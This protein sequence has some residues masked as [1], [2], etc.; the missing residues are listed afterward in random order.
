MPMSGK[1]LKAICVGVVGLA[2]VGTIIAI[3][4]KK[5]RVAVHGIKRTTLDMKRS[6]DD[7]KRNID[8]MKRIADDM[9]RIVP[10]Y[11][12]L[13]EDWLI[14]EREYI[15]SSGVGR[16]LFYSKESQLLKSQGVSGH[17]AFLR[18]Q[19]K[20]RDMSPADKF[21]WTKKAYTK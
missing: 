13:K 3:T 19:T 6:A 9:K 4:K 5:K 18:I 1:Y 12:K 8:N 10:A 15:A 14:H 2:I 17:E 21:E 20:W 11:D 16:K 7:I